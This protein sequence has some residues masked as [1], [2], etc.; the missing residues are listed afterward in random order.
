MGSA[1]DY[2]KCV[3]LFALFQ[4]EKSTDDDG[5]SRKELRESGVD[6]YVGKGAPRVWQ[7]CGSRTKYAECTERSCVSV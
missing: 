3:A 1:T 5:T 4:L 2:T 7:R 6:S